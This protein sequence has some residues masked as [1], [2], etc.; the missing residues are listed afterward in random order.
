VY[1][2]IIN[3]SITITVQ[4]CKFELDSFPNYKIDIL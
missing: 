2:F 4:S 1:G 3:M